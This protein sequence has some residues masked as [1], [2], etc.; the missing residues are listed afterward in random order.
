MGETKGEQLMSLRDE[1]PATPLSDAFSLWNAKLLETFFSSACEGDEVWL[2]VDNHE[3][4][5][6][7]PELGGDEGFIKAVQAGP[8]WPTIIRHGRRARGDS[9][10]LVFRV[11]GLVE[12][13]LY[14]AKKPGEYVDP[15]L[16]SP[17]YCGYK[18][19]TYLPF[20]AALVRSS[21]LAS[22]DGYY[23]HLRE[24]LRLPSSWNSSQLAQLEVAW[25]DLN[26]WTRDT[27]G[28]FGRFVPRRLGGYAHVGV[29]RAQCI[30]SR[31]DCEASSRVFK[32]AGLRPGQE[33]TRRVAVDVID[34]ASQVLSASFRDALGHKELESPIEASLRSLFEEW[35]GTVP[36]FLHRASDG[37]QHET[38]ASRHIE[39]ALSPHEDTTRLQIH[40]R[41][42]PLREGSDV[43]LER[44][45]ACWRAPIWGTEHCGTV[46]DPSADTIEASCTA[47]GESS[48]QDVHFQARL[49][50]EGSE[51][52]SLGEF[53]LPKAEVRVFVWGVDYYSQREELQEHPLP[54]YGCAY[55]L[56]TQR[57]A[58]EL[59]RRLESG[60]VPYELVEADGLPPG[61]MLACVRD[62]STLTEAQLAALP[63]T[64]TANS[65]ERLI[66]VVGGRSVSRASKRQY[67]S[68]DLPS[69][70]L[71]APPGTTLQATGGL[72]LEEISLP[73]LSRKAGVRRFRMSLH[74]TTHKSF[75]IT[76]VHSKREVASVTL[77]I[78]PDSGEQ[79]TLG[80][81]FSLDPKGNP[82]GTPSGLRGTLICDAREEVAGFI[83]PLAISV[84]SLGAP[85]H[86]LAPLEMASNPT[87]Q[88]LDS[89]G[90]HGTMAYGTAKDQLARLLASKG[91]TVR[92]EKILLDL[93]SRGHVE[94]ETS[95]KGHFTRI[96]A[97]PP[98]L[99]Q[100][101]LVVGGRPVYAVL[102]SLLLQHWRSLFEQ[103]GQPSIYHLAP[104]GGLL[105]IWRLLAR[106][107]T[108]L[109]RIAAASGMAGL[110]SQS[111]QVASWAATTDEVRDQIEQGAVE[112]IGALEYRPAKLHPP[113]GCFV[114]ASSLMPTFA[115]QLFRMED[116]DIIGGRVY[117]L[118]ICKGNTA[119]YG[120]VRDSRW[121]IWIALHAF[122]R[123]AKETY[124]IDD[125]CPWPLPYSSKDRTLLIPA[126]VSLPVVLE[127]ALVLCSGQAPDVIEAK[128]R[129]V[130]EKRLIARQSDGKSIA[131]VSQVY[132]D[133]ADGKWLLY[134]SVPREVA[135][136]VAGKLGASLADS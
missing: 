20:L 74:G 36:S 93:R 80:K 87:V 21:A 40:W 33:W 27:K 130:D 3:L 26:V 11:Q 101:P 90:Q 6:I 24:A 109:N 47:L 70:E 5:L 121:G 46:F 7:G 99:Y 59:L 62:C 73:V 133:M 2:Q 126:R 102:G 16:L 1:P 78:A 89:L 97:V 85:V 54:R 38:V 127:R 75:R 65:S 131:V 51:P 22:K 81:D 58:P 111:M 79:V 110:P 113:T 39:L 10:D 119:R 71:D 52:V 103:A 82:Q 41:V 28:R 92:P 31:Q 35:D 8:S 23:K 57:I 34:C 115:Y 66:T 43:V 132:N 69:I 48:R 94:I 12:Q 104:A 53:I 9:A 112:K 100:L 129:V 63:G 120:F 88:F 84:G 37:S 19:P 45:N 117:V 114:T 25:E 124:S 30:M 135:T 125:A 107:S 13:R 50:E 105:P 29:P 76:A 95:T 98:A 116:R 15:G 77:R 72:Y 86:A 64:I 14:P 44:N 49:E 108:D 83:T 118:A 136:I 4:D 96:H 32:L 17:A 18:A 123:W 128:S 56:A 122:A 61:W 42:P 106:D 134:K 91:E 68:Y 60:R 67:L 55:F